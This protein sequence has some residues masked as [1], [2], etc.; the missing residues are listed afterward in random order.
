MNTPKKFKRYPTIEKLMAE[1]FNVPESEIKDYRIGYDGGEL[2]NK[3]W[4]KCIKH[5]RI[6]GFLDKKKTTVHYWMDDKAPF[7]ILLTF[8]AHETGHLN[9]HHYQDDDK[10]EKKARLYDQVAL[11]AY[12]VALKIRGT[13]A[14]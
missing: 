10:E 12:R 1:F 4:L 8:I 5:Q 2:S 14:Q 7:E 3:E 11:Y 6:W 9:G 13:R